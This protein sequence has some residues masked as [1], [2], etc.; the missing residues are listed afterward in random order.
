[1]VEYEKHWDEYFHHWHHSSSGLTHPGDEW[2][3]KNAGAAN[4]LQE[5]E[6]LIERH[7]IAPFI[8]K[9]HKVLEIGIGGGK[10]AALLAKYCDHLICADISQQAINA[11]KSRLPLSSI[12]YVKL[13]SCDLSSIKQQGADICFCFDTLVH[14][15]PYDIFNYLAQIPVLLKGERLCIFHTGNTL[16]ELGWKKFVADYK[17]NINGQRHGSAFSVMTAPLMMQFLKEL[18]YDLLDMSTTL[19]PRDCVWICRAPSK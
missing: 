7:L 10:T 9:H 12:D 15:E 8:K 19:I 1:M 3:G 11:V 5:Y 4:S 6:A 18:Q 13:N 2:F 16:S 17:R 14:V